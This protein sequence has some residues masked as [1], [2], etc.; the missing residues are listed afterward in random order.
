MARKQSG[1]WVVMPPPSA[2]LASFLAKWKARSRLSTQMYNVHSD[3]AKRQ[4]PS[5]WPDGGQMLVGVRVNPRGEFAG[6]EGAVFGRRDP[7][8]SR[9]YRIV[10]ET[11]RLTVKFEVALSAGV[12]L[13]GFGAIGFDIA[14]CKDTCA[15]DG[16]RFVQDAVGSRGIFRSEYVLDIW[17]IAGYLHRHI[18]S[19]AGLDSDAVLVGDFGALLG[20]LQL[21]GGTGIAEQ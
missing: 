17:T 4:T 14:I 8:A 15:G 2:R 10:V 18:V 19:Q 11:R 21:F 3:T 9:H 13:D 5:G 1:G 7:V 12:A 6:R 20:F 16:L